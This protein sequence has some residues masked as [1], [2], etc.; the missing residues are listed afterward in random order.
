MASPTLDKAEIE[1]TNIWCS[2]SFFHSVVLGGD[3]GTRIQGL[4]NA[5]QAH[6]TAAQPQVLILK[7]MSPLDFVMTGFSS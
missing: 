5:K 1:E 2:L 4:L 7:D 3:T 6:Y